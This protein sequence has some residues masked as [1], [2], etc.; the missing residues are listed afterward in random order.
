MA[1][2]NSY[3][4]ALLQ[5]K[6]GADEIYLG[7]DDDNFKNLSFSGRGRLT[8]SGKK[9]NPGENEF[10]QIV[11]LAH[12]HNVDVNYTA[13]VSYMVDGE[14]NYLNKLYENYIKK[15]VSLGIDRII[16]G[17]LGNLLYL[18]SKNLNVPLVASV[19]F[20]TFNVETADLLKRLGVM[21]V[22]LPHQVTI[23]E[24]TEIKNQSNLEVEVFVG[25]GCSNIDGSCK[26][27]HNAGEN[28]KFGI[29][30]KSLYEVVIDGENIG[31]KNFM[32]ATLDCSLCN[33]KRL[34]DANVDVVKIIGRDQNSIFTSSI[35]KIHKKC[36]E[37][38]KTHGDLC[39]AD[40]DNYIG[41]VQWWK[42]Q[43]CEKNVCRYSKNKIMNSYI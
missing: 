9:I 7:L 25:V 36:I 35:T 30:C 18:S 20:S 14:S 15:G 40:I 43:F 17:D 28:I 27:L 33:L 2:V 29:P 41:H 8:N 19:F 37:H 12:R 31:Y 32:D 3:Q 26:L 42:K 34:Y 21:R 16:V 22:V 11:D 6:A 1:P 39:K 38:L 5:I 10:K 24:I 4:S 23:E 13:N